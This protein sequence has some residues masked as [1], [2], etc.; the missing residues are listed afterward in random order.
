[1]VMKHILLAPAGSPGALRAAVACG[2]DAVYLGIDTFNARRGAENFTLQ[3]IGRHISYAHLFGVKVYITL[4]ILVKDAETD[5]FFRVAKELYDLGADAF[6]LQ[7]IYFGKILSQYLP[8]VELHLST[9]AGVCNAFGAAVAKEKGFCRIVAARETP[10]QDIQQI[11]KI[12]ETEVFVQGALCSSFSGQCYMSSFIGGMSGNRGLC[13]QPCRQKYALSGCESYAISL[14]DL[15]VG[16]RISQFIDAGV[17]AFKI[18]GRMRRP[19]YVAAAT[20]YYRAL[21]DGKTPDISPLKRAFNRGGYTHGLTFGQDENFISSKTQSHIGEKIGVVKRTEKGKILVETSEK[22][23][24]GSAMKILR[25]GREVGNALFDGPEPFVLKGSGDIRKGDDVF[26]TTDAALAEDFPLKKLPVSVTAKLAAGGPAELKA[27]AGST[28]HIV[29]GNIVEKA[30]KT[31]LS[32]TNI[33]EAMNKTDKFPFAPAVSVDTKDAF[34]PL[35][36]LN[37]LRRELYSGLYEKL[38]ALPPRG[39][40]KLTLPDGMPAGTLP[41]PSGRKTAVIASD[42][43]FDFAGANIAVFAPEDYRDKKR[44]ETFFDQTREIPQKYLYIPV[45][46]PGRDIDILRNAS[47][48][49]DGIYAQNIAGAKMAAEWGKKIFWGPG[50]HIFN[51]IDLMGMEGEYFCLS[52]ELTKNESDVLTKGAG[53]TVFR[54]ALGGINVM[55]FAYCPFGKNCKNCRVKEWSALTDQSGRVFPLRRILLGGCL[56][57]LFN[58]VPLVG[59]TEGNILLN[60]L[61]LSKGQTEFMLKNLGGTQRIK[62]NLGAFTTGHTF[63]PVL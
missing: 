54:H 49:F 12:I 14:A 22:L 55:T 24:A 4:N 13:K 26:I 1:M 50:A 63:K 40:G 39:Y 31:P 36:A 53:K 38:T 42:F 33:T 2:A 51:R 60:A 20:R 61:T 57:E 9:Q 62:E 30:N 16:E 28:E 35:S 25:G 15:C 5:M 44:F 59:D 3:N 6:I 17:A 8:G 27:K 58:C 18:E 10:L 41:R 23:T 56:F 43:S 7:D 46:A 52:N 45:F 32:V 48:G 19:E 47:E 37:A 21:L 29:T 11:S 34:L